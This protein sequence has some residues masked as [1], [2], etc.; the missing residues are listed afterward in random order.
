[1]GP[2]PLAR[3]PGGAERPTLVTPIEG[4][5]GPPMYPMDAGVELPVSAA[6]LTGIVGPPS[7]L[8]DPVSGC[9]APLRRSRTK[10]WPRLDAKNV[11]IGVN[12]VS[13]GTLTLSLVHPR[14]VFKPAILLN[15]WAIIAVH[16]HP[17]G[18]SSPSPE[19]RTLTTR[20]REAGDLLGIRLLDHLILG[21]DRHYSFADQGWPL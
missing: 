10:E 8:P 15:A 9:L 21:D 7:R 18:D 5:L 14:E 17:S 1:M 19:N 13:I 16:N 20:L 12:I 3:G 4:P 6:V 11:S 2:A